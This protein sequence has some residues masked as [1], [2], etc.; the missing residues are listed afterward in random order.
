MIRLLVR[1]SLEFLFLVLFVVAFTWK[2]LVCCMFCWWWLFVLFAFVVRVVD[3][4]PSVHLL[5]SLVAKPSI[6][7]V[8]QSL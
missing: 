5:S 6:N 4:G 7:H 3:G 8:E 1:S 2:L